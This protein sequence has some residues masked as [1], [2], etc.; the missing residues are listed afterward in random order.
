V[1]KT[2]FDAVSEN[3]ANLNGVCPGSLSFIFPPITPVLCSQ[4]SW[5]WY[6]ISQFSVWCFARVCQFLQKSISSLPYFIEKKWPKGQ[7]LST[8]VSC[9]PSRASRRHHHHHHST[10]NSSHPESL[11][12]WEKWEQCIYIFSGHANYASW[13]V[14]SPF[15]STVPT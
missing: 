2:K 10:N 4:P 9:I 8:V 1:G 14:G 11:V 3:Q 12:S 13:K 15:S 7:R 6:I 5:G